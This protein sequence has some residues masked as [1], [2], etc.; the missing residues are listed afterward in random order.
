MK[1]KGTL[2]RKVQ[3]KHLT[4][5]LCISPQTK[6]TLCYLEEKAGVIRLTKTKIPVVSPISP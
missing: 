3:S 1:K 4:Y 2:Y 6:L 5:L